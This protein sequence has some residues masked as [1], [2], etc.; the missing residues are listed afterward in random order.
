MTCPSSN[1]SCPA[2]IT[3][4]A[5]QGE[6]GKA[7]HLQCKMCHEISAA[8]PQARRCSQP[9][10]D[11]A[12][13][14]KHW[15]G[16][17]PSQPHSRC[18]SDGQ[19]STIMQVSDSHWDAMAEIAIFGRAQ[20]QLS[21]RRAR[22][23]P[24]GPAMGDGRIAY[25]T[26]TAS[27]KFSGSGPAIHTAMPTHQRLVRCS[28]NRHGDPAPFLRSSFTMRNLAV[29]S[30]FHPSCSSVQVSCP[31]CREAY[32]YAPEAARG[33]DKPRNSQANLRK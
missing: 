8:L 24:R 30:R 3:S 29:S 5:D 25:A 19:C 27:S 7:E 18:G 12:H 6:P 14:E 15:L 23:A 22:R 9:L 4:L 2:R 31:H 32:P 1:W 28:W 26:D 17:P 21:A 20:Q 33:V 10:V 16:V 13:V 11:F